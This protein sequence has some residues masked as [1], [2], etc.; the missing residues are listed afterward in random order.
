MSHSAWPMGASYESEI[1][2]HCVFKIK[3]LCVKNKIRVIDVVSV[4]VMNDW[5]QVWSKSGH[6]GDFNLLYSN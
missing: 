1:M 3:H 4:N 5:N 6:T 2:S